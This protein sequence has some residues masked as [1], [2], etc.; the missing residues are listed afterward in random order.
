MDRWAG[1]RARDPSGGLFVYRFK[2]PTWAL[3]KPIAWKPNPG[4]SQ[5]EVNVPASFVTDFA[6][7][8]PAF[9]SLLRPDGEYSYA[10]VFHDYLYWTQERPREEADE[11]FRL[12]MLD[13]NIDR[14]T[15]TAIY[16]AV[17]AFGSSAW[18]KNVKLRNAGERRVIQRFPD[19]PRMTWDEWKHGGLRP[20]ENIVQH[21]GEFTAIQKISQVLGGKRWLFRIVFQAADRPCLPP[22]HRGAL[23][24]ARRA[25]ATPPTGPGVARRRRAPAPVRPG[26]APGAAP[27]PGA[28]TGRCPW[29]R[30][31]GT[32]RP[33]GPGA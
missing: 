30:R 31:E 21:T 6:S 5:K 8:P 27:P 33:V 14:S 23:C 11:I 16:R 22:A 1:E 26:P 29:D 2:D 24:R 3:L 19:D 32:S 7:I 9:Y 20:F 28:A 15:V 4:Q 17:R 12:A 10:A 18:Q 25:P 13:F